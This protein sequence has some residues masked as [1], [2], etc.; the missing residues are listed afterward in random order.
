MRAGVSRRRAADDTER[1]RRYLEAQSRYNTSAAGQARNR[2]YEK[3][4]GRGTRWEPAR[5]ALAGWSTQ[6]LPPPPDGPLNGAA[7]MPPEGP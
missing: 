4:T 1:R 5:N 6:P 2:A 7:D 3:R